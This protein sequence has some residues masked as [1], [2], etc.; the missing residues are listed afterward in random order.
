LTTKYFD[1][2]DGILEIVELSPT[3]RVKRMLHKP[4]TL[5]LSRGV[6]APAMPELQPAPPPRRIATAGRLESGPL[7]AGDVVTAAS[8]WE[9][10][11][12]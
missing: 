3:E 5:G 7:R 8:G 12:A 6:D 10:S 1:R 4:H 9:K 2:G 11:P